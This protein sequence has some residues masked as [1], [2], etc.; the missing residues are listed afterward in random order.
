MMAETRSTATITVSNDAIASLQAT[1][2]HHNRDIQEIQKIEEI[3]TK[4]M[5]E[6]NQHLI[7]SR[8]IIPNLKFFSNVPCEAC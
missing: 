2:N 1:L 5:N 3:Q 6:M 4:T 8:T 7:I